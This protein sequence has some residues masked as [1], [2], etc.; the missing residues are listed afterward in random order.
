MNCLTGVRLNLW[1]IGLG[2]E[3]DLDFLT[4][5][6]LISL[7]IGLG[8]VK[9]INQ[10]E[11]PLEK[12]EDFLELYVKQLAIQSSPISLGQLMCGV[13]KTKY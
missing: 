10:T 13:W 4:G 9:W 7:C 8:L 11:M 1:Y 6:G 3:K 2:L 5:L 12:Y